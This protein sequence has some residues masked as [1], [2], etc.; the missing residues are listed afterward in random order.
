MVMAGAT[1]V[2]SMYAQKNMRRTLARCSRKKLFQN[3]NETTSKNS[4]PTM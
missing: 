3:M 1:S 2:L 4:A